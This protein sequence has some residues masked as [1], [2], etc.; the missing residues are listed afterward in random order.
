MLVLCVVWRDKT[1]FG[2]VSAVVEWLG[3]TA[4]TLMLGYLLGKHL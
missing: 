4:I 3:D 2:Q 1:L